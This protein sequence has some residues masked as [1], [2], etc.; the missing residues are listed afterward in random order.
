MQW[1]LSH[2]VV[3]SGRQTNCRSTPIAT[4]VLSGVHRQG[5]YEREG[6]DV[7]DHQGTLCSE[8][9]RSTW[10]I[11]PVASHVAG[12]DCLD[13]GVVPIHPRPRVRGCIPTS[14]P[15]RLSRRT[16]WAGEVLSKHLDV[17]AVAN[18]VGNGLWIVAPSQSQEYL[19]S[20]NLLRAHIR[21]GLPCRYSARSNP[22]VQDSRIGHPRELCQLWRG[23]IGFQVRCS[24]YAS[25]FLGEFCPRAG[26]SRKGPDMRRGFVLGAYQYG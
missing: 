24:S 16:K 5:S 6:A 17:Q 2:G 21:L 11:K 8:D 4:G 20:A 9:A 3:L 15:T 18:L 1:V 7:R 22:Q 13:L 14:T 12:R 10:R 25:T 26:S 19:R 23:R